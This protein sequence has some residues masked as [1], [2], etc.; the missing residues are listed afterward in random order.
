DIESQN[1]EGSWNDQFHTGWMQKYP[2]LSW[3]FGMQLIG[4]AAWPLTWRAFRR[5]PDMGWMLSKAVGFVGISALTLALGAWRGLHFD[6]GTILLSLLLIS[7]LGLAAN[8]CIWDEFRYKL[9]RQWRTILAGELVFLAVFL[10][11]AL[12]RSGQAIFPDHNLMQLTGI[13]RSVN[14]P[15]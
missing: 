7:A 6:R 15:P 12:L 2:L 11:I 5:L 4:L 10:C 8:R 13:M 1:A 3:W 14:L 9:R